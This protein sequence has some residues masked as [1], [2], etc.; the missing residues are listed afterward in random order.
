MPRCQPRRQPA[1]GDG[2]TR[3]L[4]RP[5]GDRSDRAEPAEPI[6]V[7][8]SPRLLPRNHMRSQK[9]PDVSV[10]D[11]FEPARHVIEGLADLVGDLAQR[12][13]ATRTG[14]WCGMPPVLSGQVFRQWAARRLV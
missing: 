7:G 4:P 3:S 6:E 2:L 1:A 14:A 5:T 8:G 11:D 9:P 12:A 13:A 10:P